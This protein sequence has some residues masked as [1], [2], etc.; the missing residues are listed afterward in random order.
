MFSNDTSRYPCEREERSAFDIVTD[1]FLPTHKNK[2][3]FPSS[4]CSSFFKCKKLRFCHWKLQLFFFDPSERIHNLFFWTKYAPW[5]MPPS[6]VFVVSISEKNLPRFPRTL[7]HDKFDGIHGE[8]IAPGLKE[9]WR[10]RETN[11]SEKTYESV[12]FAGSQRRTSFAFFH[13]NVLYHDGPF[14]VFLVCC[15]V[16]CDGP[17]K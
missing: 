13:C 4:W 7:Y 12:F 11:L 17:F 8:C 6:P 14:P 2:R 15:T 1:V 5:D 16:R 10:N 9:G 3:K